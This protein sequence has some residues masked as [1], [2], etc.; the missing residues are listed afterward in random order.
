MKQIIGAGR[1]VMSA[2]I[3]VV[4][5]ILVGVA[6]L[7]PGHWRGA[8]PATWMIILMVRI[9]CLLFQVR[10]TCRHPARLQEHVGFVFPN[11]LSIL[12]AFALLSVSPVRFLSMAEVAKMPVIGWIAKSMGTVFVARE[13]PESR[14]QARNDVAQAFAREPRPPIV[15]FPEGHLGSGKALLP[16]R[17]GAFDI[18]A[19]NG[20]PY[21]PCALRYEPLEIALWRSEGDEGLMDTV[22]RL[23][24]HIG[25]IN[26]EVIPLDPVM[27]NAEDDAAHLADQTRAIIGATLALEV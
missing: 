27:P 12:D 15:I 19:R 14:R 5:G 2:I 16:F 26:A 9:A 17:H 24:Q 11:H 4:G 6:S 8:R 7:V 18:A 21:L 1:L 3:I 10:V 22:W 23:A 13:N 20:I 25:P